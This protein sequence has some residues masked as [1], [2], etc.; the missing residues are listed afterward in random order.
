M[1]RDSINATIRF[2][3]AILSDYAISQTKIY[4]EIQ[5]DINRKWKKKYIDTV[6]QQTIQEPTLIDVDML[7]RLFDDEI[8]REIKVNTNFFRTESGEN[9][10]L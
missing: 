8:N 4:V 1:P 9:S 5:E 10:V 7:V 3:S 6:E 2:T